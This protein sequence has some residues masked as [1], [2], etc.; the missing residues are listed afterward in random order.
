MQMEGKQVE[1]DFGEMLYNFTSG[2]NWLMK[3]QYTCGARSKGFLE[4]K[5]STKSLAVLTGP[6]SHRQEPF[7]VLREA[8][9]LAATLAKA[10]L[11]SAITHTLKAYSN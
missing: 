10:E 6:C 8:D 11:R 4:T 1:R 2:G 7:T 5:K 3:L 9:V